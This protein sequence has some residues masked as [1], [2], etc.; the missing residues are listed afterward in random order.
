[1][2]TDEHNWYEIHAKMMSANMKT[3]TQHD[4]ER[5]QWEDYMNYISC[6][7]ETTIW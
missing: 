3:W 2:W 1:M 4:L 6:H 5:F 7:S